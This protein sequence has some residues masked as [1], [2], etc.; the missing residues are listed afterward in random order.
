MTTRGQVSPGLPSPFVSRPLGPDQRRG[1]W[2]Q[3]M[4]YKYLEIQTHIK[5]LPRSYTAIEYLNEFKS[6]ASRNTIYK[7]L[8]RFGKLKK[9][10]NYGSLS[11][12]IR[13]LSEKNTTDEY[14]KQYSPNANR[15]L[16]FVTLK[17]LGKL[18]QAKVKTYKYGLSNHIKSLPEKVTASE[19]IKQYKPDCRRA[20]VYIALKRLGKLKQENHGNSTST[21]PPV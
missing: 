3:I 17:R 11:L 1:R 10:A 9:S 12:H 16:V 6:S 8:A 18:K 20:A 4:N 21:L 19:Y 14:I 13:S 2:L 7:I 5:K 15:I